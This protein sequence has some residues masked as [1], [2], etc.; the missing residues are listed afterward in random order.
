MARARG[1]SGFTSIRVQGGILPPDFLA[2]VAALEAPGQSGA[3]Y[4]LTKS[5]S[6]K[7][8]IARYWRM[9]NDWYGRY[10]AR[11][12]RRDLEASRIGVDDWLVPFTSRLLG[13]EDLHGTSGGVALEGR[14]FDLTHRACGGSVPLLLVTRDYD[15]DRAHLRFGGNERRV[16]PHSV[17]QEYLNAEAG[18]LWGLVSNGSKFRIVRDNPSLAGPAYIEAD[19]DQL[20]QEELYSDFAA[21]WLATHASR[22]R[23]PDGTPSNC[24][25]ETWRTKAHETGE[26]A[27]DKLRDG[28]TAALRNLGNGFLEHPANAALR[29]KLTDGALTTEGY[30]RQLLRVVYRM[31]FLFKAEERDLLHVPEATDAMRALYEG[32]YAITRLRERALR[33]RHYDRKSDLWM[34]LRVT[35]GALANG[36]PDLGLPGLGGLYR[37]GQCPDLDGAWIR[38]RSLLEAVR[39]LSYLPSRS[40]ERMAHVNFRDMDTEELGSVYESLLDLH[41]S[42]DV[43]ASPWRFSF[44]GDADRRPGK[45]KGVDRKTSGSYYT[46]PSLAGELV[47]TTLD[48]VIERVVKENPE[49]PRAAVLGLRILDPACGS[50]HFLLAA[51]RRLATEMVR[52]EVGDDV[53]DDARHRHALREVVRQCVYGVDRNPLATELCKTA[54]WIETHEPGKPL[55]FLDAHIVLGDS[56][57]GVFDPKILTEEIPAGAYKPLSGDHKEVCTDLRK[58]NRQ[59][60]QRDFFDDVAANEV[61]TARIDLDMM[62]DDT[63]EEVRRKEMAWMEARR[64]V[65]RKREAL[66]ANLFVGAFFA[67]KTID[68]VETVP[69]SRDIR[70][71]SSASSAIRRGAVQVAGKLAIR[72]RFLH[73]HLA[74]PEIM[75]NDGFDVVLANPPWERIKLQEKEFFG[76]RSPRIANARTKAVR[77]RLIQRLNR[78]D[79]TEAEKGLFRAFVNAKRTAE[80]TSQFVRTG[81]RFPLTGVGDVNT[82]A[83]L[84]ELCLQLV[85]PRGR[86]GMVVPTGISTDYS[87]RKFFQHIVDG[88]R[89]STLYDFENRGGVF[90]GVHRS[91]KFCLLTLA[92]SDNPVA[93]AEFAFFLQRVDHLKERE[94]RYTLSRGDF[95]LFNPNTRTC[96]IFRTRN[97]MDIVRKMHQRAGVLWRDA[98]QSRSGHNPWG[99]RFSRMFDM[100]GDS[101]LFMTQAQ[102]EDRG[103]TLD[104]NVYK[105]EDTAECYVPLYEA[106]MF[107]QFDH[108][109]RTFDGVS[110][111]K[112]RNG[113]GRLMTHE[114]KESSVSVAIPRYWV[115]ISEVGRRLGLPL[116]TVGEFGELLGICRTARDG[117]LATDGSRRTARDGRLATDGSRRTARDGRLATD[118]SRRTARDG[119]LATD[120]SRFDSSHEPPIVGRRSV[121]HS[122]PCRRLATRQSP[123][124]QS[125]SSRTRSVEVDHKR[126]QSKNTGRFHHAINR[127]GW[128]QS[129]N[130]ANRRWQLPFRKTTRSTDERTSIAS[131]VPSV[132]MSDKAPLV[133]SPTTPNRLVLLVSNLNSI[134]LDFAARTAVGG[135]DLSYFIIKQLPVFSPRAFAAEFKPGV[136]YAD[137]VEVAALELVYTAEEMQ[138][139]ARDVGYDGPP[140][141]WDEER[142]HRLR[143]EIDGIFAHMYGLD[144]SELEWILDAPP[145]S[146]SFP[147][148]KKNELKSFGEYRTRRLVLAAFESIKRGEVP[149]LIRGLISDF[150]VA[151]IQ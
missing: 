138:W 44:V 100:S 13:F 9:G 68:S 65:T 10:K 130:D 119:R 141:R 63:L 76:A 51:A 94:R 79:A 143:S 54:L 77:N 85:N 45:G 40:K 19:L 55:T 70:D 36:A 5:L 74:F 105:K 126:Y 58:R 46:P 149:P 124:A 84:A 120:G 106:K 25:M 72:H 3:D 146:S 24:I 114:E 6:I 117:R 37:A 110:E 113:G 39:N 132:G 4:D 135:T 67:D 35:F 71:L 28:V 125:K 1:D 38:N 82:Y 78:D 56:I 115:P 122:Q 50:G 101:D 23:S 147:T 48:P 112:I 47:R 107:H 104:G 27:R 89:L 53:H 26:R 17:M 99:L 95:R 11:R 80:A 60:S 64:D 131:V 16:A 111:N 14:R 145:P 148:L 136:S 93:E 57:V 137:M 33:R 69:L 128:S 97:D 150:G 8:E 61:A 15:L 139:F 32:G 92:G 52:V 83:V 118:G 31:L 18:A 62:P 91:T 20:F 30:F 103:W 88:Q 73:W 41:P 127:S 81:G 121:L 134:V 140:F 43:H 22:F 7:D 90:P 109:F 34:G 86:A 142:R 108:R 123:F 87:T 151:R 75:R 66:K 2:E 96:P 102:L 21:L 42:I 144:H 49:D 59:D 116:D 29:E 129:G 133:S 12:R 98:N